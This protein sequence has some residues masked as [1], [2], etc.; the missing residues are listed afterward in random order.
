[1]EKKFPIFK[2]LTLLV[3]L[4]LGMGTAFAAW[5]GSIATEAPITEKG[6]DGKTYYLNR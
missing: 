6:S 1:M 3:W 2:I 5:D 4:V